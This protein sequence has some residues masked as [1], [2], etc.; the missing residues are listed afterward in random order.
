VIGRA[1]YEPFGSPVTTSTT[2]TLPRQQ[3]T[4]QERDGEVGADY[5]GARMYVTQHGRFVSVDPL[6]KQAIK[7]PQR[8]NRFAYALGN[9][10]RF[11]DP[12]GRAAD[13]CYA[14]PVS[15]SWLDPVSALAA[16]FTQQNACRSQE[17][18][19][20]D[21]AVERFEEVVQV[22]GEVSTAVGDMVSF[23]VA[24]DN[25]EI[26]PGGGGGSSIRTYIEGAVAVA[27]VLKGKPGQALRKFKPSKM[28]LNKAKKAFPKK[29][30]K[31][32]K[33]H[34]APKYLGG[35]PDG[36]LVEIDSAY[37]QLITNEFRGLHPY[38]LGPVDD[39]LRQQIMDKVYQKYPIGFRSKP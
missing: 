15:T 30:G 23:S 17:S 12:D 16:F 36:D 5:F 9:P 27:G 33:H 13:D 32:D 18:P 39:E 28:A 2:G 4:G 29:A 14:L 22:V 7:E 35:D 37:H 25:G 24:L 6:Y 26:T 1:D 31:T 34:E 3:F 8:W 38:G 21:A 20:V 11:R 19:A 10:L